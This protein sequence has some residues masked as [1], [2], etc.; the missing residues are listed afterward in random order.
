M[1]AGV[2]VNE[3]HESYLRVLTGIPSASITVHNFPLPRTYLQD[4]AEASSNAFVASL[5]CMIAFCFVPASFA[6][7][8]VKEREVKAKHQQIISGV[9][10]YAYWCST[11]VWDTVSFMPTAALVIAVCWA[12]NIKSY[13]EGDAG[14]AFALLI[15]MF[16]PAVASFT[17]LLSY[18]FTSHSSAQIIIMFFN[19]MTGLCLM[20]VSFVLTAIPSTTELNMSL[21]Y[22]FRLFPSFCL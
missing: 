13:T 15:I 17:Y 21:R 5:F 3:V 20:V 14:G 7:F 12:Y 9:S 8:V 6:T 4:N 19:F 2:Y 22:I 16:G 18:L 10:I 1:F 11:W